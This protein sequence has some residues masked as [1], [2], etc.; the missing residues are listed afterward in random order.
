MSVPIEANPVHNSVRE[1]DVQE[2]SKS[3]A[4][5]ALLEYLS[6]VCNTRQLASA[7]PLVA[8]P[9]YIKAPPRARVNTRVIPMRWEGSAAGFQH[10]LDEGRLPRISI[11]EALK[12]KPKA[13]AGLRP[14]KNPHDG[15]QGV[16][17]ADHDLDTVLINSVSLAD[18]L[19][20][21]SQSIGIVTSTLPAVYAQLKRRQTEELAEELGVPIIHPDVVAH[22][23]VGDKPDSESIP[24]LKEV[25]NGYHASAVCRTFGGIT[26]R[27]IWN[28]II[29]LSPEEA[30]GLG[31]AKP[32]DSHDFP[33]PPDASV[34][35]ARNSWA[36]VPVG[37]IL[38]HVANLPAANVRDL[39]Y[40]VYQLKLPATNEAIPFLVMDLWTLD[41]Y[42]RRTIESGLL[43][44][45][46]NRV[47]ITQQ[48]VE[49][50]PLTSKN[51]LDNCVAGQEYRD[52]TVSF[53]LVITY[54]TFPRGFR[55][56]ARLL[57]V[58]SDD[59]PK[60]D[61]EFRS[62]VDNDEVKRSVA[63]GKRK[64]AYDADDREAEEGPMQRQYHPDGGHLDGLPPGR[65]PANGVWTPQHGYAGDYEASLASGGDAMDQASDGEDMQ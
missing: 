24:I 65:N 16:T 8:F 28:G 51:W 50:V 27:H 33:V 21:M 45:H 15:V 20:T 25:V 52:G 26:A 14:H 60:L 63:P 31:F 3:D 38:S 53:R 10:D 32:P 39:D 44:V 29:P 48:W 47:P 49:I 43:A 35:P 19:N 11:A 54:T 9:G 5:P 12:E 17:P 59:F 18:P 64:A 46:A 4:A 23:P 56:D 7:D 1:E 30:A 6:R 62:L 57:P 34:E 41:R 36:L 2:P 13:L 22:I 37:H 40:E 55:D 61:A 42:A 58:L